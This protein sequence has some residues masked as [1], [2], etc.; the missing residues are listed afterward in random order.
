MSTTSPPLRTL[1]LADHVRACHVDGQVILLDLQRNKYIGVSGPCLPALALAIADWPI[2]ATAEAGQADHEGVDRW[3]ETFGRQGLLAPSARMPH[4]HESLDS[5][6]QSISLADHAPAASIPW[7]RLSSLTYATLITTRWLKR[8]SLSTIADM[9]AT[10]RP[11]LSSPS[12]DAPDADLRR[13]AAWYARM[14]PLVITSHDKCLHD[15]LA[16]LRFL[17][18]EGLYPQWVIGVRT[19]PFAAH[20]WVQSGDLVL[21]DMHEYVR[22][23]TPIL[24]V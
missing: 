4:L 6:T 8:H 23:F 18:S 15:S 16:L 11:P 12:A 22:G 14:R 24:V 1:R 13:A 5:P 17:A 10:M 3:I 20:S 7:R 9:V 2:D 21:N 19:R